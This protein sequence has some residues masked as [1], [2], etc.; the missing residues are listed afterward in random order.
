MVSE[1]FLFLCQ[2][3][4]GRDGLRG[5]DGPSG[6]KGERGETGDEGFEGLPGNDLVSHF[7]IEVVAI[8]VVFT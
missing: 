3:E 5:Q 7:I 6:K 8:A 2:G 4:A 1:A